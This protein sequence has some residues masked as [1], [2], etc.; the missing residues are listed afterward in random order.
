[1]GRGESGGPLLG[2][3]G[4]DCGPQKFRGRR[5]RDGFP[6]LHERKK[7]ERKRNSGQKEMNLS[8]FA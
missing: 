7:E 8:I 5:G 3:K 1:M 4:K 6:T 2:E